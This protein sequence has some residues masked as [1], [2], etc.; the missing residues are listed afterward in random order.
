LGREGFRGLRD[1]PDHRALSSHSLGSSMSMA[2]QPA[3]SRQDLVE[4]L[5]KPFRVRSP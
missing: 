5:S 2:I 3:I 1:F 4:L